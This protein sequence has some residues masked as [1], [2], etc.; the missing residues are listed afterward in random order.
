[1]T[2]KDLNKKT[3][4]IFDVFISGA[5]IAGLT[6]A[7]NLAEIGLSVAI[8]DPIKN[9]AKPQTAGIRTCAIMTSLL[10]TLEATGVL[11]D[12]MDEC[13][14]LEK[15]HIVDMAGTKPPKDITFDASELDTHAFALNIPNDVLRGALLR[16]SLKHPNLTCLFGDM[17]A[18]F[19]VAPATLD[20]QHDSGQYSRARLLIGADGYNSRIRKIANIDAKPFDYG[21]TA[22]TCRLKHTKPHHNVSSETYYKDGPFTLVPLANN[23]SS[24]VWLER[25]DNA[26]K[27]MH[28]TRDDFVARL[29]KNSRNILGAIELIEGPTSVPL[30][31]MVAEKLAAP[32]CALIAEAA[33]AYSPVGAQGLNTSLRDIETLVSLVKTYAQT[34][35]DIGSDTLLKTYEE[36]RLSDI[37]RRFTI[38]NNFGQAVSTQSSLLK[39]LRGGALS[40]LKDSR[41]LRKLAMQTGYTGAA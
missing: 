17:L 1:M 12:I 23:T 33:H 26:E 34:G 32:R 25:H 36:K 31:G 14:W 11:P 21:Q 18:E 28:L 30:R 9:T 16:R 8:I 37:H 22:H 24:L 20:I 13:A 27:T 35:L 5:G 10:P 39:A 38:V 7:L 3:P 6:L 29:Q 15:M 4:P 2:V 19:K 40:I 41:F